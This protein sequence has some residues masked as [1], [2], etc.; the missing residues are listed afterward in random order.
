M[1]CFVTS[2][3]L[4]INVFSTLAVV[5]NVYQIDHLGIMLLVCYGSWRCISYIPQELEVKQ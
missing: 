4:H 2:A 5:V 1:L 3:M